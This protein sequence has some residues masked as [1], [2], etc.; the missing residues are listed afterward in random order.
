MNQGL[1]LAVAW[2]ELTG[3]VGLLLWFVLHR[4]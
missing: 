4:T 1:I 3:L 2:L